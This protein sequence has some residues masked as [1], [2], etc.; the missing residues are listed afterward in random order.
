[1]S[2]GNGATNDT[3]T[4]HDELGLHAFNLGSINLGSNAYVTAAATFG[5]ASGNT[6]I[7][8]TASTKTL[9]ITLGAQTRDESRP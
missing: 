7:A 1:M 5:G 6:S 8:W 3:L 4:D 2:D 9:V